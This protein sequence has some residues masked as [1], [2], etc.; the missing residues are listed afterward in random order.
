MSW[1]LDF[2]PFLPLGWLAVLT[3]LALGLLGAL[4]WRGHRRG[5][6][7]RAVTFACLLLALANPLLRQEER[8]GLKDIV[9]VVLD[10]SDSQKISG[11]LTHL[12]RIREV[13]RDRFDVLPNLDV[14]WVETK[15]RAREGTEDGTHLFAT[16]SQALTEIPS[17]RLAGVVLVTD[18]QIH[19]VPKVPRSLG[20]SVPLHVLLTGRKDAFD[21][22]VK[23]VSAPRFGIIGGQRS[24]SVQVKQ[25]GRAPQQTPLATLRIRRA[26]EPEDVI[27]VPVEQTVTV[28]F[29]FPHPGQNVLEIALD[30]VPGEL[31]QANNRVVLTAQGI[32]ENL[33]VLLISGEPH[34]GE[35][36]WRNLLKSDASVDLV[37]FTILRPPEKQDGTPI[38][39]LSLIAFPTRELF[40]EKL[41]E[42]DL[43]IFDR[44]KRRGV[45]P[46]LYLD[47]V[48]RYV[49]DGGA[50]L[51]AAGE[52]YAGLQSL[53]KTPLSQIL[54]AEPTGRVIAQPY[55]PKV[56][57]A[58]R[59][60][61]VTRGLPGG[62]G[63][64]PSWGRWFRLVAAEAL[65]DDGEILMSGAEDK[66]LLILGRKGKGRVALLLSD[67]AWLWA[68]GFDGG[69]PHAQ[70][71]RRLAHWLMKE[72][73]L[74]EEYLSARGER[75]RLKIERRSMAETIPP[76]IVT[77]PT[78]D[79]RE[80]PLKKI[81]PGLWRGDM[82]APT[83][84]LYRL[85]SG[86]KQAVAHVGRVNSRELTEIIATARHV[87]PVTEAT[88][89]GIFWVSQAGK[90]PVTLPRIVALSGRGP[91]WGNGWLG[92][93]RRD[94]YLVRGV[95]ML[96][97]FAGFGILALL[98]GLLSVTWFREGR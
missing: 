67:H 84:G 90:K 40:S 20:L 72:P 80:V 61:P 98:L 9:L 8:Q 82:A 33:R 60:H 75:G 39:Q 50:V 87:Q 89:G 18:G 94:A 2:A 17:G 35:R 93:V 91:K 65:P 54:P 28:A 41:D 22:W 3:G 70:L 7:L 81:A 66:P 97:L 73:D 86:E 25:S 76:V 11:R 83:T 57:P 55:R 38:N 26:G 16:V 15:G 63:D 13:L 53:Y 29:D 95:R 42:F 43:V 36:T 21:R 92:L 37:H 58:G 1:Q 51:V 32:R 30:P 23:V 85:T 19:D 62:E 49:T 48:A 47:N 45:L 6:I 10:H 64:T 79:T 69:G 14:R 4:F 78:G 88:G 74:E 24:V 44:Y 31:T 56:T 27:R 71:L 96:P 52:A 59:R 34:P 68:R 77:T 5:L 46:L 12:S